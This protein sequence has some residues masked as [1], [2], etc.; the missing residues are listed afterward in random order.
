M[1]RKRKD[2]NRPT[3]IA[4]SLVT[5]NFGLTT[6][7]LSFV[8][9]P[10]RY[11]QDKD[12]T[13]RHHHFRYVEKCVK[14]PFTNVTLCDATK[15][16]IALRSK[17]THFRLAFYLSL[18]FANVSCGLISY[19]LGGPKQMFRLTILAL[20]LACLLTM[21]V[22]EEETWQIVIWP[23][24]AGLAFAHYLVNYVYTMVSRRR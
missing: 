24:L 12:L 13:V 4:A 3:F 19:W 21:N 2:M 9:L 14:D 7:V 8:F 16:K 23:T 5:V 17:D 1:T 6:V 22:V 18:A 10:F 11:K 20:I 15:S